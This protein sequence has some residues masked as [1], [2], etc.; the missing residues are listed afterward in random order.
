[1]SDSNFDYMLL[2]RLK[3]DCEYFLGAGY[4]CERH[5]W[6]GNVEDQIAKMRELY[7][8]VPE[9]PEWISMEDINQYEVGMLE[10]R[11]KTV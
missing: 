3:M 1:M 8:A 2:S 6:A 7:K 5:L 4:G 9:Q 10:A 11:A